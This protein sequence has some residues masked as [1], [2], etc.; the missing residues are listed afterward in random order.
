MTLMTLRASQAAVALQNNLFNIILVSEMI[1][2]LLTDLSGGI[3]L[4]FLT[5]VCS[6]VDFVQP[7]DRRV[8]SDCSW[9][10]RYAGRWFS[11]AYQE[12]DTEP[13]IAPEVF[14]QCTRVCLIGCP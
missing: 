12:R 3:S 2:C 10:Q 4:T 7:F 13:R 14:R 8:M 9:L 11:P 5:L 6:K 1:R